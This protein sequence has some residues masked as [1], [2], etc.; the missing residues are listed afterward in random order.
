VRHLIA[1]LE[2]YKNLSLASKI[3]NTVGDEVPQLEQK[4]VKQ[5]LIKLREQVH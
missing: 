4:R 2:K 1:V 3:R 5:M